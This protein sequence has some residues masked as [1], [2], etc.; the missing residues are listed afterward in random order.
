MEPVS[1]ELL[2]ARMGALE[3]K[4]DASMHKATAELV[5]WIVGTAIAMS[6]VAITVMT[7]VLNNAVPKAF[8]YSSPAPIVI[9]LP[10]QATAQ[11]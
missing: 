10:A 1:K 9:Q 2:E 5:K 4:L 7:F 3:A 8:A 6:A 11:K